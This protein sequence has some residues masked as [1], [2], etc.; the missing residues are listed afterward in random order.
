[1]QYRSIGR[2]R[3]AAGRKE[4]IP[5]SLSYFDTRSGLAGKGLFTR[6]YVPSVTLEPKARFGTKVPN[7]AHHRPRTRRAAALSWRTGAPGRPASAP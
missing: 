4:A 1:M 5:D 2:V 7:A 3:P 6:D